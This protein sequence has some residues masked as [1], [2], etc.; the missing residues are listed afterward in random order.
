MLLSP[1]ALMAV[2]AHA[3]MGV[4]E[5]V[6]VPQRGPQIAERSSHPNNNIGDRVTLNI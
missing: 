2:Q 1:L 4:M 6:L 3:P 5:N